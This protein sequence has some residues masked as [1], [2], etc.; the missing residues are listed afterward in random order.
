MFSVEGSETEVD[1]S[2]V[3]EH[4]GTLKVE[5]SVSSNVLSSG[6]LNDVKALHHLVMM[7]V[8]DGLT[9]DSD[10]GLFSP[11]GNDDVV[12]LIFADRNISWDDISDGTQS[13]I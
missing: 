10:V 6:E 8:T 12:S 2:L 7:E 4:T 13:L 1:Q 9:I 3:K 5:S 11:L